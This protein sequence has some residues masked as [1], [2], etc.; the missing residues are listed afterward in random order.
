MRLNR[1]RKAGAATLKPV[2]PWLPPLLH[3]DDREWHPCT[4]AWWNRV[5]QSPMADQYLP[6]D[7]DGLLRLALLVDSYYKTPLPAYLA[8]IRLQE[9]RFGL[10]PLDR[11]RLQWEMSRA[12]ASVKPRFPS[13]RRALRDDPRKLLMAVK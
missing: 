3:P 5:W 2:D 11:S 6:S 10:S 12:D 7:Q 1:R 9:S 8:E 13:R 4:I